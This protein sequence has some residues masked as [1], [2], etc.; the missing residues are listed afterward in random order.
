MNFNKPIV[1]IGMPGVGKTTTGKNLSRMLN[2]KHIDTD[3]VIESE[4]K[5]SIC[6]IV[7]SKGENVFRSLEKK[8][9]EHSLKQKEFAVISTGG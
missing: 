3:D 6:N 9:L 7:E 2:V 4:Q 5:N 1:L 8:C